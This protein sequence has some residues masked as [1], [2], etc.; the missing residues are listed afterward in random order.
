[1]SSNEILRRIYIRMHILR[2]L[3]F[4]EKFK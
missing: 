4:N 3:L 2:I 1:M